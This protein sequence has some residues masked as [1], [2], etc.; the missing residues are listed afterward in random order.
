L[1]VEHNFGLFG[2]GFLKDNFRLK[3]E[4]DRYTYIDV[5]EGGKFRSYGELFQNLPSH[6]RDHG[7]MQAVQPKQVQK[8]GK[9]TT[10]WKFFAKITLTSTVKTGYKRFSLLPEENTLL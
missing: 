2:I 9:M 10:F 3:A 1:K 7:F 4:S 5:W 8:R 6:N